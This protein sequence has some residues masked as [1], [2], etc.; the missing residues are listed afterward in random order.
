M[1]IDW[2][3]AD[4]EDIYLSSGKGKRGTYIISAVSSGRT[5]INMDSE[6]HGWSFI[7]NEDTLAE[8]KIEAQRF[9]RSKDELTP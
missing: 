7:G 1:S 2:N 9:D 5:C 4:P 3:D 8:A 6:K